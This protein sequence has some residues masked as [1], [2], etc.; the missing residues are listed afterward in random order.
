MPFSFLSFFNLFCANLL[1][2]SNVCI[3]GS[4]W[5]DEKISYLESTLK[6]MQEKL[7]ITEKDIEELLFKRKENMQYSALN[8]ATLNQVLNFIDPSDKGIYTA[9]AMII[10]TFIRIH[11]LKLFFQ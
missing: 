5:V 8:D 1:F 7:Q 11:F 4:L 3:L 10:E 6:L 9:N 2:T